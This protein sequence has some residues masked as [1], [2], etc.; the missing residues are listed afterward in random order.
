MDFKRA[1]EIVMETK[2]IIMDKESAH[3]ITVKGLADYVTQTDFKVQ[4][5]LMEKLSQA[6]PEA[7]F[8]AEEKENDYKGGTPVWIIDPI[9]GTTNLIHGCNMSAVSLA[10][11]DSRETVFGA[12]YNP[13]TGELFRAEKGKGAFLGDIRIRCTDTDNAGRCLAAVG[14]S[15]YYKDEAEDNFRLFQKVFLTCEDIRRTGSA[16]LDHCYVAAGRFDAYFERHLK[17]WDYAAGKL[18]LEEAGGKVTGWQGEEADPTKIWDI[19][20]TNGKVHDEFLEMIK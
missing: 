8:L 11:Y 18:I 20:A 13:F 1:L 15:P 14:T 16:A 12:V 4:S 5:F 7:G 9:D 10:Y 2:N 19:L 3:E 6:Y 17:P